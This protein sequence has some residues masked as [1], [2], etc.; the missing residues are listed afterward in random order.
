LVTDLNGDGKVEL[1]LNSD[2]RDVLVW[3]FDASSDNGKNRGKFLA[4]NLNTNTFRSTALPTGIDNPPSVL[5]ATIQLA[6][7]Y[8]N[9]FNPT[10]T[11]DF[12]LPRKEHVSIEIFNILGQRVTRLVDETL[13]AGSH[14]V[15]FDGSSLASGVYLY[16]LATD[17]S[18]ISRKMVMI[19]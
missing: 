6:Q 11:I 13:P 18:Q 16:R 17:K 3:N 2:N 12:Q 4:D 9:P 7:N 1:I 14:S 19:K 10:T 5:P 8:P 15:V